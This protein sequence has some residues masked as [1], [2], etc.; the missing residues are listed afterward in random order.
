[1]KARRLSNSEVFSG[2]DGS[3]A[4][5]SGLSFPSAL[6]NFIFGFAEKFASHM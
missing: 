2:Q 4:N 1:M 6:T 5:G 3:L